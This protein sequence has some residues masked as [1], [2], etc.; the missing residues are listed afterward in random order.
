MVAWQHV[1]YSESKA[2]WTWW[3]PIVVLRLRNKQAKDIILASRDSY[4]YSHETAWR[5]TRTGAQCFGTGSTCRLLKKEKQ[6]W[7][8]NNHNGTRSSNKMFLL[9]LSWWS[10]QKLQFFWSKIQRCC[11][12]FRQH[13]WLLWRTWTCGTLS[14]FQSLT[15]ENI[16]QNLLLLLFLPSEDNRTRAL[17][18]VEAARFVR[19]QCRKAAVQ[20]GRG[21]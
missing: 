4:L 11:V 1:G 12:R 13:V 9:T 17:I 14:C 20:W 5:S 7:K 6:F 8:M 21:P 15:L 16:P 2:K 18:S 19:R 3:R 10:F